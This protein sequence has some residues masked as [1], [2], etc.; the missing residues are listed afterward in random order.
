MGAAERATVRAAEGV[1]PGLVRLEMEVDSRLVQACGAGRYALV[2][3]GEGTDP[4]LPRPYWL[5]RLSATSLGLLVVVRGRGSGWLA[6]RRPGY[7]L[8][9]TGP[10]GAPVTPAASTLR[11]LLA[12]DLAGLGCL[13]ALA[14]E[15]A[16][17]RREVALAL[18][19]EDPDALGALL[20]PDVELLTE[21][22]TDALTWADALFVAGAPALVADAQR[23]VR[24]SGRRLPATALP[25]VPLAC[26][27]GACYGCSVE[28]R[29]G[30]RRLACVDGP[31]FPLRD[32]AWT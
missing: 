29:R 7:V 23:R 9:W 24:E 25:H 12:G 27:V 10:L 32:L 18:P 5:R 21:L 4:Y 22:D 16:A 13:L 26:G 20:S 30:E 8:R 3:V 11:M 6:A 31:A 15:A 19:G 14:D 2:E 1:R 17:A 28:T